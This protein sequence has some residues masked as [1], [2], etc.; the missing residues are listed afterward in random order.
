[1]S[2]QPV[3][4]RTV[5]ADG[6]DKWDV[7]GEDGAVISHVTFD[8]Q[9]GYTASVAERWPIRVEPVVTTTDY[10]SALVVALALAPAG[11]P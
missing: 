5:V 1:M 11:Q 7:V 3:N 9:G 8:G 4:V 6:A 10:Y 2:Q